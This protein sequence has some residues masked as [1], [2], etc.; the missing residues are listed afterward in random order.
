MYI[1]LFKICKQGFIF[2]TLTFN[3]T[4]KKHTI[5]KTNVLID[6]FVNV[7]ISLLHRLLFLFYYSSSLWM[8][9]NHYLVAGGVDATA[10]C[11]SHHQSSHPSVLPLLRPLP[12]PRFFPSNDRH[13]HSYGRFWYCPR[14][15]FP[16]N[17]PNLFSPSRVK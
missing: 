9:N 1:C 5:N 4:L 15:V 16:L 7:F 2:H 11:T 12:D 6:L 14:Q 3:I 17:P 10:V 13:S 8:F